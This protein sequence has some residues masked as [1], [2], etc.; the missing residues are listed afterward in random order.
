MGIKQRIPSGFYE[1]IRLAH[2]PQGSVLKGEYCYVLNNSRVSRMFPHIPA[3]HVIIPIH[4]RNLFLFRILFPHISS[5]RFM[6]RATSLLFYS[7]LWLT[8]IL[9]FST[10]LWL[11]IGLIVLIV[12]RIYDFILLVIRIFYLTN[13]FSAISVLPYINPLASRQDFT[14]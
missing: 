1:E 2:G 3:S 12:F 8:I 7:V 14:C 10:F 13:T 5:F 11:T 9:L 4:S 6:F